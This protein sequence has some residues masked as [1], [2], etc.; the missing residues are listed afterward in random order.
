MGWGGMCGPVVSS[1]QLVAGRRASA[2][3]LSDS[4]ARTRC[5][6]AVNMASVWYLDVADSTSPQ[7][8]SG[9]SAYGER[10]SLPA[11]AR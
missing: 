8:S 2:C 7:E 4:P 11:E 6:V 10:S 9:S 5:N 1:G 3:G